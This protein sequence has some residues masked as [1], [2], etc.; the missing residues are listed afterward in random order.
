MLDGLQE[1]CCS[2]YSCSLLVTGYHPNIA[3]IMQFHSWLLDTWI[4]LFLLVWLSASPNR[5]FGDL[6]LSFSVPRISRNLSPGSMI[7]LRSQRSTA[8]IARWIFCVDYDFSQRLT[9]S[10]YNLLHHTPY[11]Q[12][13]TLISW[14]YIT[15]STVTWVYNSFTLSKE[16][17]IAATQQ[18][19]LPYYKHLQ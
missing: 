2:W 16:S 4:L 13:N 19:D 10:N 15:T 8:N 17:Q 5:G 14:S 3:S 1:Q 9:I 7:V 12:N 18:D 6:L 11:G